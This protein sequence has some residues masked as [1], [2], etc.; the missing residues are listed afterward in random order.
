MGY[1]LPDPDNDD[2][3]SSLNHHIQDPIPL[4]GKEGKAVPPP[5]PMARDRNGKRRR[6]TLEQKRGMFQT[7]YASWWHALPR[8]PCEA[9]WL[10]PA[11]VALIRQVA[12]TGEGILEFPVTMPDGEFIMAKFE[13]SLTTIS[14]RSVRVILDP[15]TRTIYTGY[16]L[17]VVTTPGAVPC[18]SPS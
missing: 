11:Y 2:P 16:E 13:S 17:G 14:G 8:T 6:P 18:G 5:R 9:A 12:T 15:I 4:W 3:G 10:I 7:N 1:R